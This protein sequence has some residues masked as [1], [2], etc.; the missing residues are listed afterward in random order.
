[1]K[2]SIMFFLAFTVLQISVWINLKAQQSCSSFIKLADGDLGEIS[3]DLYR[4]VKGGVDFDIHNNIY[5]TGRNN[6]FLSKYSSQ[7]NL[8]WNKTKTGYTASDVAVKDGFVYVTSKA[9]ILAKY[10]T[11]GNELLT[12]VIVPNATPVHIVADSLSNIYIAGRIAHYDTVVFGQNTYTTQYQTVSYFLVKYN[13]VGQLIWSKH[14]V[15][16]INYDLPVGLTIHDEYLYVAGHELHKYDLDGNFLGSRG[17]GTVSSELFGVT[18]SGWVVFPFANQFNFI[19]TSGQNHGYVSEDCSSSSFLDRNSAFWGN[20]FASLSGPHTYS[21]T[22]KTSFSISIG[23]VLD[24]SELQYSFLRI[25]AGNLKRHYLGYN[26]SGE[27]IGV[28]SVGQTPALDTA[29]V[30]LAYVIPNAPSQV[31]IAKFT[32][33][34][35]VFPANFGNATISCGGTASLGFTPSGIETSCINSINP[36][37]LW[38]PSA[39]L[40]DTSI[41][42]PIATPIT[43]TTY[44]V[45][46]DG[47][48]SYTVDVT[49]ENPSAF[50]YSANG[51]VVSFSK[52]GTGCNSFLWDFGNGN[53]SG[54]NANPMVTYTTPG[55]YGVCLQCNSQPSECVQCVN[56]TVPGNGSTGVLDLQST[57][58]INIFPNPAQNYF[59]VNTEKPVS[60]SITSI[61]GQEVW[62]GIAKDK[63]PVDINSFSKGLYIV[64]TIE[65]GQMFKLVK[66]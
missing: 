23:N 8:I 18:T 15:P 38:S 47:M 22:N 58:I 16:N 20:D 44:T 50:T 31:L 62:K 66:E 21:D 59:Y 51:M 54:I 65:T 53:T 26:K 7:G 63:E 5:I 39:G 27:L 32:P 49:V 6:Y 60:I 56:I 9:A 43:S 33:G 36:A 28:F 4:N 42:N 17:N 41:S 11:S 13:S 10:D 3:Q 29:Y 35:R 40:S 19:D 37:F 24:T 30:D 1:M 55:T 45:T 14:I 34:G 12:P 46:V 2:K 52:T 61:F 48:C 25:P 57:A 64:K